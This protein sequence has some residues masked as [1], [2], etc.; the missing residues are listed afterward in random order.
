MNAIVPPDYFHADLLHPSRRLWKHLL[1]DCSQGT[2]E[3]NILGLDRKGDTPGALAPEIWFSFLKTGN[4]SELLGICDHNLRDIKGLAV[5]TLLL[6]KIA[7]SPLH[8]LENFK[9]DLEE[10]ALLWRE[11]VISYTRLH[12]E[13]LEEK[14]QAENLLKAAAKL[15]M[16]RAIFFLGLDLLKTGE[17]EKGR[18]FLLF[19]AL[20]ATACQDIRASALRALAIDA[21]RQLNDPKSALNYTE[22]ALALSG[23]RKSQREELNRRKERLLRKQNV[24]TAVA[25]SPVSG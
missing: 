2:I 3:T 13:I 7:A 16:P 24:A 8:T 5:L 15:Y 11:K 20:T 18:Q 17:K 22:F 23:I 4:P 25:E 1:A 9:F 21:E 14:A 6:A 12:R 10:L 19:L